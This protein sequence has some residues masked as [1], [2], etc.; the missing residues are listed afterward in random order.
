MSRRVFGLARAHR[1]PGPALRG[2]AASGLK[3]HLPE[4]WSWWTDRERVPDLDQPTVPPPAGTRGDEPVDLMLVV[5]DSGSTSWS[6]PAA[7]RYVAMRRIVN[8]LV[9]GVGGPPLPDRVGVVH[10]A[11]TPSPWLPLT[12]LD[13]KHRR[14]TV[15]MCLQQL[16]GGGTAIVP[17]ITQASKLMTTGSFL[18]PRF[19]R[20]RVTVLFTDGESAEASAALTRAVQQHDIGSVHV[21]VLG[22]ELPDQ[23]QGVPLGSVTALTELRTPDDVEWVLARALYRSLSL[24]WVGPTR[25]PTA[26][27]GL[28]SSFDGTGSNDQ[29]DE[30]P[31]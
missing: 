21:V 26:T 9:E 16:T 27:G 30:E 14:R 2:P 13:T 23:W 18:H 24:G 3:L 1:L 17:A 20:I 4:F 12:P 7:H 10:F 28:N 29:R 31:A 8:L 19:S 25:P 11:D 5:D 6:D 22:A 15:R